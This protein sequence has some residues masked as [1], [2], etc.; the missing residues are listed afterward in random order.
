MKSPKYELDSIAINLNLNLQNVLLE[1][2]S[3]INVLDIVT[4]DYMV[5]TEDALKQIEE[6][7]A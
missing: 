2:V 4:S 6:V 7:L 1:E 5:V 3:E